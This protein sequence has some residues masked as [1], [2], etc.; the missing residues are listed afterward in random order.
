EFHDLL[1]H[2][3]TREGRHDLPVGAT[4]HQAGLSPPPAPVKECPWEEF[5]ALEVPDPSAYL[6]GGPTFGRVAEERRSV[7]VYGAEPLTVQQL[8]EFLYRAARVRERSTMEI[9]TGQGPPVVLEM[10][11]RP[12]PAAGGLYEIEIYPVVQ[13]CRGL[14]PG[15]YH[16]DP[17]GHRLGKVSGP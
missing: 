10:T 4:F 3:R 12:Y 9:P 14:G 15:L 5:I 7:R 8:G 1:F 6:E 13:S 2:A 17:I 16:Y 11:D